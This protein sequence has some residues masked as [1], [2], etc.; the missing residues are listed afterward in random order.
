MKTET[1]MWLFPAVFMLHEFEEI[2]FI[3]P[4]VM[5]NGAFLRARFPR[6]ASRVLPRLEGL[7]TSSFALAV[8]EEFTVLSVATFISVEYGLYSFFTGVVI[9]YAVHLA[10]HLV[11]FLFVGRYI[12]AVVTSILTG[13]YCAYAVYF[14]FNSRLARPGGAVLWAA[15][16]LAFIAINLAF[17]HYIASLFERK[18]M[19]PTVKGA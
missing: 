6:A 7:S 14:L 3:K 13:V 18:Y 16:S 10:M 12:P 5:K 1:L 8:A 4:W 15:V 17:C 9:A 19:K 11:Q 2:I